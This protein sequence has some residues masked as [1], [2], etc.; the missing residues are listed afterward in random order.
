M[1]AALLPPQSA[2]RE[3]RHCRQD[4]AAEDREVKGEPSAQHQLEGGLRELRHEFREGVVRGQRVGHDVQH[5]RSP[6]NENEDRRPDEEVE[7]DADGRG[8]S[9]FGGGAHR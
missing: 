3:V 8:G 6:A 4:E 5:R 9:G 2:D 1:L 7:R